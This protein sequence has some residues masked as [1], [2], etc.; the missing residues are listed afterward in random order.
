MEWILPLIKSPDVVRQQL[1]DHKAHLA[2]MALG[3]AGEVL[4]LQASY[5]RENTIEELGDINFYVYG[6]LLH[7][8]EQVHQVHYTGVSP[9]SDAVD[10]MKKYAIYGKQIDFDLLRSVLISCVF[11]V[12]RLCI[13][14][15][16]YYPDIVEHNKTKLLKGRYKTGSYSD[17]QAIKREDK[18][19]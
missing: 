6:A 3:I 15:D 9:F 11:E 13:E 5:S 18:N 4:E 7:L 8:P 14:N 17:E 10:L 12:K 19:D 1:D 16:L 2:H